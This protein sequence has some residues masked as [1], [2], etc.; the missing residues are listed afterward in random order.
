MRESG[1]YA[2]DGKDQTE[3]HED[4]KNCGGNIHEG[5]VEELRSRVHARGRSGSRVEIQALDDTVL[6][7][8]RV[9]ASMQSECEA[10]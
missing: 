2:R 10:K 5:V 1:R 6:R 7:D 3:T 9:L 8:A 4:E